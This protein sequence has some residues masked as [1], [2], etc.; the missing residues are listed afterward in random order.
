MDD[1]LVDVEEDLQIWHHLLEALLDDAHLVLRIPVQSERER[2]RR[3][4]SA[5]LYEGTSR[6][7]PFHLS[8]DVSPK[9]ERRALRASLSVSGKLVSSG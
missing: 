4:S 5:E 3:S 9:R 1:A 7:L 8:V 2:P 6:R